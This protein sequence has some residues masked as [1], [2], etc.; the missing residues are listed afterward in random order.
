MWV[1]K[2]NVCMFLH[3]FQH[4]CIVRS[5]FVSHPGVC[6]LLRLFRS[7]LVHLRVWQY[8]CDLPFLNSSTVCHIETCD[9]SL[10]NRSESND[11]LRSNIMKNYFAL[12]TKQSVTIRGRQYHLLFCADC[13]FF[14]LLCLFFILL[15]FIRL[16]C[17]WR[18][19]YRFW[20]LLSIWCS[21]VRIVNNIFQF[22]LFNSKRCGF[23]FQQHSNQLKR[24]NAIFGRLL[25]SCCR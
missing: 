5:V 11:S 2:S 13:F 4:S 12:E 23:V 1:S 10:R 19:I 3:V 14:S 9:I 7:R 17:E 18:I 16:M 22:R 24:I 15:L 20:W 25:D 8:A 21:F 6:Y